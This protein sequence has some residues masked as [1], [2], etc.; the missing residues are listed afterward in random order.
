L[1]RPNRMDRPAARITAGV[2]HEIVECRR[3]PPLRIRCQRCGT[4]MQMCDPAPGEP[5]KPDQ[6][7]VCPRCGRHFWTTYPSPKPDTGSETQPAG[8]YLGDS[9]NPSGFLTSVPD[10]P[11]L[12]RF[13]SSACRR[14][15]G[16]WGARSRRD[17]LSVRT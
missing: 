15:P 3:M 10:L 12:T 4:E 9:P 2:T 8:A 1:E 7:W 6:F 5:W 11:K 14:L 13:S 17:T 16:R